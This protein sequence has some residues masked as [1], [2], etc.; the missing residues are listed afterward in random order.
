MVRSEYL[1]ANRLLVLLERGDLVLTPPQMYRRRP[2]LTVANGTLMA[3]RSW[4]SMGRCRQL[5]AR[6]RP[7]GQGSPA[8]AGGGAPHSELFE[9]ATRSA[10]ARARLVRQD[11]HPRQAQ[12]VRHAPGASRR[13][14]LRWSP[15]RQ[16]HVSVRSFGCTG[17]F[18]RSNERRRGSNQCSRRKT[19]QSHP[20]S[21]CHDVAPRHPTMFRADVSRKISKTIPAIPRRRSGQT[22]AAIGW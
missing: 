10:A 13:R 5:A 11:E 14:G 17:G 4:P 21:G 8:P 7:P 1:L 6:R 19:S 15:L 22:R 3:R 2:L 18:R 16:H 20:E 9:H 12:R